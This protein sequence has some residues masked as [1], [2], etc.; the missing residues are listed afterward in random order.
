M[1]LAGTRPRPLCLQ[2]AEEV[3]LQHEQVRTDRPRMVLPL[4]ISRAGTVDAAA[5]AVGLQAQDGRV[6]AMVR[7]TH[8]TAGTAA[9]DA[10]MRCFAFI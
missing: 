9:G 5:A 6:A 10:L 2:R 3:W 8:G 1:L 4:V 7:A